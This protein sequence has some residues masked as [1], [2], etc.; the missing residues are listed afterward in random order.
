MF[1]RFGPGPETHFALA[2]VY[3]YGG[4]LEE[5]QRQCELAYASL[6]TDAAIAE[7]VDLAAR[8]GS[9]PQAVRDQP[10]A[11]VHEVQALLDDVQRDRALLADAISNHNKPAGA[12]ARS[13][14]PA[15]R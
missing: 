5:A 12:S 3:R 1:G 4:N 15:C 13:S 14:R 2:Y 9:A 6:A 7:E 11:V 8:A 10:L